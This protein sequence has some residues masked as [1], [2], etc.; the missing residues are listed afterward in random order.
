[1]GN[2]AFQNASFGNASF[3]TGTRVTVAFGLSLCKR[4]KNLVTKCMDASLFLKNLLIFRT[5]TKFEPKNK[6]NGNLEERANYLVV[7]FENRKKGYVW[8]YY[9]KS[10]VEMLS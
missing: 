8:K 7:G 4:W 1:M 5:N 3:G 6:K 2:E 10:F 9:V